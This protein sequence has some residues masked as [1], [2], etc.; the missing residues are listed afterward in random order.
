MDKDWEN[1]LS[2]FE[3]CVK[4]NKW[5]EPEKCDFLSVYLDGEADK[6]YCD[7]SA[8]EKESWAS[9]LTGR[10]DPSPQPELF[11]TQLSARKRESGEKLADFG[12]AIRTLARKAFPQESVNTRDRIAK[13][14]FLRALSG[15]MQLKLRLA[16]PKTLDDAIKMAIKYEAMV[17]EVQ[18]SQ[19][20]NVKSRQVNAT[21]CDEDGVAAAQV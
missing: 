10:F 19:P 21:T 20:V 8:E 17:Q 11:E 13:T 2:K 18:V 12:N 16:E 7:L 6:V 1:W 15:E 4:V 14:Q 9:A 3:R 5:S